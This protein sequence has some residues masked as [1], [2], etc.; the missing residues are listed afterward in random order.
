AAV[1]TQ[2]PHLTRPHHEQ[3]DRAAWL[4][5]APCAA[6]ANTGCGRL[7]AAR[8]RLPPGLAG[9]DRHG[10]GGTAEDLLALRG[11]GQQIRSSGGQ[12]ARLERP[13]DGMVVPDHAEYLGL[14]QAFMGATPDTL[15][16][17]SGKRWAEALKKGGQAGYE[18]FA[19]MTK[20]FADG[21]PSIPREAL[22]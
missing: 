18:A 13:Y 8:R 7:P 11:P 1:D 15:K 22:L 4:A 6:P 20:E 12:L 19:Q 16:T 21:K 2:R 5:K 17:A 9:Q 10:R 14:P 3:T